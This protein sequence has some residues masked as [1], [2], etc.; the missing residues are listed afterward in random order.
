MLARNPLR[1][2]YQQNYEEIVAASCGVWNSWQNGQTRACF[3]KDAA[4]IIRVDA[5]LISANKGEH[6]IYI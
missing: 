2:D 3:R 4:T 5:I 6:D 1:M